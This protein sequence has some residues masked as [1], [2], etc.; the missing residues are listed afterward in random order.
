MRSGIQNARTAEER[1]SESPGRR[2]WSAI[3]YVTL[4]FT[5]WI[6]AGCL[7]SATQPA[8]SP[9]LPSRAP[10]SR[11]DVSPSPSATSPPVATATPT[12]SPPFDIP[13]GELSL[14]PI[15]Y[16]IPL[17][18]RRVTQDQASLFFELS[19]SSPGAVYLLP[20]GSEDQP[21]RVELSASTVEHRIDFTELKPGTNYKVVVA[22]DDTQDRT[23]QPNFL[24]RA[25]GPV[26]LRTFS[27]GGSVRFAAI[28]DASF[29]DPTTR[30]L[31][32]EMAA[33]SV[34]FVLHA[35]DVVD[36]T[37]EGI[38]PYDS[39]A[40]KF[41]DVF[42]PVLRTGPVYT[43]PGNH[44]YDLDIRYNGEP[45]YFHAF[46]PFPDP[47]FPPQD[48]DARNQFYE[49]EVDGVR[50]LMLDSQ[51]LFGAPGREAETQWLKERLSEPGYRASI[52][53]VHVAPFSSSSVHPQDSLPVRSAWV[54]LFEQARVAAVISGHFHQ[55]ERLAVNGIPYV[56]TGGGSSTL[57][58][59]GEMLPQ[60][61]VFRRQSHFLLG[62]IDSDS[63]TLTAIG[64][65]GQTIDQLTIQLEFHVSA[66]KLASGRRE[67]PAEGAYPAH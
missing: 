4:A 58:A 66:K 30:A 60:S 46:P 62:E 10:S 19:E 12:S 53:V 24:G 14:S 49:F 22:L 20:I 65:D 47:A 56:V 34:D 21:R 45:F 8:P 13:E 41:Y 26:S 63:L 52:V 42:E 64:L 27:G 28:G 17:T 3:T 29:G 33:A 48:G 6:S 43:V 40:A 57:Y 51:V 38:N 55:Y 35:G 37:D 67:W 18:I 1:D 36:E 16:R 50:F 54:P 25:W 31:I 2:R 11:P 15:S 59:P 32:S 44:D 23:L 7:P 61:Q 5:V 9:P 39:Y